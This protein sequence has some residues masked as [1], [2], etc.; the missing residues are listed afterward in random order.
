MSKPFKPRWRK[1]AEKRQNLPAEV[2]LLVNELVSERV[3]EAEASERL[4]KVAVG[5]VHARA[6]RMFN[7]WATVLGGKN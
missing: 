7:T 2:S 4:A 6:V 3:T 5:D 1:T